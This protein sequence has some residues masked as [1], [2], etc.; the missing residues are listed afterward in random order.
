MSSEEWP[1]T[2]FPFILETMFV[3]CLFSYEKV[4]FKRPVPTSYV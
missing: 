2:P 3:C 1:F 4:K